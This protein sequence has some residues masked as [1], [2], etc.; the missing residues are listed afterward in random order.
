MKFYNRNLELNLLRGLKDQTADVA[1]MTVLTGRRRLGKTKLALEF[2]RDH[3]HLYF[4]IAKK[5][6][7]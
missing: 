1:R 2:A 6:E 4:F 7:K 5:S 3:K